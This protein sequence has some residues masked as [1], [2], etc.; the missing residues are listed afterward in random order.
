VAVFILGSPTPPTARKDVSKVMA[1]ENKDGK[2]QFVFLNLEG[3]QETI[4]EAV[5]QA[6]LIINRGMNNPQQ[7]RTLIA[8]PVQQPKALGNGQENSSAPTQQVFEVMEEETQATDAETFSDT[9]GAAAAK[10]ARQRRAPRP[11]EYMKDLDPNDAEV[12]LEAFAKQKGI[13][14]DSTHFNQYLLIGAWLHKYKD[15]KEIGPSHVFT[16]YELLNW[17]APGNFRQTFTDMRKLH[18]YFEPSP[19]KNGTW[20][21]TIKGLNEVSKWDAKGAEA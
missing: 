17:T 7:A 16:C 15:I 13:S 6:G 21:I 11:P 5:R 8:V 12:S 20:E 3:D 9:N 19:K 4:Q 18:H 2:F 1:K 10:S 14:K